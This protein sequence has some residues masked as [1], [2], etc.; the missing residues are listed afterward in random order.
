M[1]GIRAEENGSKKQEAQCTRRS[2]RFFV[3]SCRYKTGPKYSEIRE[4]KNKH[5]VKIMWFA[6][7][8][9]DATFCLALK[10]CLYMLTNNS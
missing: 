8:L 1:A 4:A 10:S 5:R 2:N 7:L 3:L 9:W 6:L